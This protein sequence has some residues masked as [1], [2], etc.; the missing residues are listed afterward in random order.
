MIID[1]VGQVVRRKSVG[2]LNHLVINL[3]VANFDQT[4]GQ[5]SG[6]G[7]AWNK[8]VRGVFNLVGLVEREFQVRRLAGHRSH[9]VFGRDK[10]PPAQKASMPWPAFVSKLRSEGMDR[11][12]GTALMGRK[13]VLNG[14]VH[15]VS[16]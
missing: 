10:A 13:S 12:R 11:N 3:V 9:Q 15:A 4:V 5:S 7:M 8:P 2:L 6:L 16:A 1:D 14:L